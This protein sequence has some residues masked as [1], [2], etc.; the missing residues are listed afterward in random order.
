MQSE[1]ELFQNYLNDL[2]KVLENLPL[3]PLEKILT[4][5]KKVRLE[6]R[7]IFV[8]GNG[9]SA[10]TASHMVCDL[11]KNT[12]QPD[13]PGVRVIGLNDNIPTM[14]AFANDEGYERVFSEPLRALVREGDLVIAISG[15]GNS[16]NVLE[17][18]RTAQN[19]GALTVGLTG[20]EGGKLIDLVDICLVVPSDSME[21]IEDLHLVINHML[22]VGL[23]EME[24]EE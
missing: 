7:T 17:G 23:R 6:G 3:E 13:L 22:T 11:G 24:A 9:G 12:R 8:F 19:A 10:S 18:I 1:L 20:F 5:L 14:T 21:R 15:S 16:L 4:E 2:S